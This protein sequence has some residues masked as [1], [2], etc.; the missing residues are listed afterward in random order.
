MMF[1]QLQGTSRLLLVTP[2]KIQAALLALVVETSSWEVYDV[3]T[4]KPLE[5][6][7]WRTGEL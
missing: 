6:E 5:L 2:L 1:Q 3:Y 4:A 7:V